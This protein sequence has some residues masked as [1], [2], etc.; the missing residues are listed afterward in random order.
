MELKLRLDAISQGPKKSQFPGPNPLPLVLV[1]DFPASKALRTGPYKP[2][3]RI[4]NSYLFKREIHLL[5]A[6]L[7]RRLGLVEA[8][9]AAIV[10]KMQTII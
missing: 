1:M 7:G 6:V 8:C 10:P 5:L 3:C 9:E 4:I 2:Y